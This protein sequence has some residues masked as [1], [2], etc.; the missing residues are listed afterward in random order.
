MS[1]S[2]PRPFHFQLARDTL[3]EALRGKVPAD[4]LLQQAFR[5]HRKMGARDRALVAE[6]VYDVLRHRRSLARLSGQAKPQAADLAAT[7]LVRNGAAALD[8]LRALGYTGNI[9]PMATALREGLPEDASPGERLDLPDALAERL[10]AQ[11]GAQEAQALAGALNRP[12]PVDLRVNSLKTDRDALAQELAEAGFPVEPTPYSPLGLR[13]ENRAPLFSLPA[14]RE[15]RFE[16]QDEGSQL[17][18]LLTDAKP[19]ERVLDLCAGAGGKTLHLGAGM[20]GRGSIVACDVSPRRLAQLKPRLARAGLSNV[21]SLLIRDE[22]DAQ[23]KRLRGGFDRVLVDAP[24]SGTG[25]LRRNPDIK[26]RDIDLEGLSLTQARLLDAAARLVRPGGLLVY[27][28]CSLL[29]EENEAAVEAFLARHP[30][31]RPEPVNPYL[32]AMNVPLQSPA[33]SLRLLPHVHGTDGFFVALM[34]LPERV[35]GAQTPPAG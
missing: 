25:T 17:I 30:Q 20:Q 3:A 29:R 28:T 19:G 5:E 33:D 13:R 8:D 10:V 18:G 27:A 24:C 31:I 34:R 6:T 2:R 7:A 22:N 4:Q 14:F 12:A 26:W 16:V 15:G 21:R 1:V 23:L 9:G 35:A 32:A 11:F